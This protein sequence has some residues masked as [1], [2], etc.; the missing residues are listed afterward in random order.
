MH[1]SAKDGAGLAGWIAWLLAER[2]AYLDSLAHGHTLTPGGA[3]ARPVST[4][5]ATE[6]AFSPLAAAGRG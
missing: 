3:A 1:V 5:V 6:I 4:H 2:T